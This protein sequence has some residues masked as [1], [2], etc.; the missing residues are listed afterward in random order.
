MV[1]RHHG[2]QRL[3]EGTL[4]IGQE[5]GDPRQG[6]LFFGIEDMENDADQE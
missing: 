5:A 4:W 3:F 6:L 2:S 1:G